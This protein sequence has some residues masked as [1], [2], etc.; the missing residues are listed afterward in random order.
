MF[1]HSLL[2]L[3]VL[4]AHILFTDEAPWRDIQGLV[5]ECWF[6]DCDVKVAMQRVLRRQT[7]NGLSLEEASMRVATN[8]LPNAL[9]IAATKGRAD[10]VLPA[11]PL[12]RR[13]I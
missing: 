11:L 5:D 7:G 12:R 1:C 10:L 9:K 8:D 6:V 4:S 2:P 3:W 13:E